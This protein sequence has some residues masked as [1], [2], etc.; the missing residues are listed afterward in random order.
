MVVGGLLQLLNNLSL[1]IKLIIEMQSMNKAWYRVIIFHTNVVWWHGLVK[2]KQT[3]IQYNTHWVAAMFVDC[4][5]VFILVSLNLLFYTNNY[6]IMVT[7]K[8]SIVEYVAS[9]DN[10]NYNNIF[11]N[12]PINIIIIPF[13]ICRFIFNALHSSQFCNNNLILI[14]TLIS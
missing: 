13:P 1:F 6:Y 7:F 14:A 9:V 2:K 8:W 3:N 12:G 4:S 11:N 5:I 10:D